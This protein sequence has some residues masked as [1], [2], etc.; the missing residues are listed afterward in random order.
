M[1]DKELETKV[2]EEI[3]ESDFA[4]EAKPVEKPAEEKPDEAPK[5]DLEGVNMYNEDVEVDPDYASG[6]NNPYRRKPKKGEEPKYEYETETQQKIE[7]ARQAF[8]AKYRKASVWKWI[9][10][11]LCLVGIV[12]G[13]VLPT[14][15]GSDEWKASRGPTFI[16]LG[17]LVAMILGL[18]IYSVFSKRANNKG[19]TL[20]LDEYYNLSNSYVFEGLN[21]TDVTGN[22]ADK[23]D[24]SDF[25]ACAL[26]N[27]VD[28]VGSRGLLHFEYKGI[29]CSLVDCSASTIIGRNSSTVFVGKMLRVEN[30][31]DADDVIVYIKGN[32]RA[33]PPTNLEGYQVVEDKKDHVVYGLTKKKLLPQKTREALAQIRTDKILVDCAIAIRKGTTYIMMGYEDSLMVPPLETPFNPGPLN[34]YKEDLKTV[35]AVAET[36]YR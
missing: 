10:T 7:A 13:Y 36:L 19:I 29:P 18:A 31:W 28:R 17:V 24:A 1:E 12:L 27:K 15:L 9:L 3:E 5:S 26:Y 20:Y 23:I 32:K 25:A 35:L 34:K 21:L 33:L 8:H 2:T 14:F 11:A 4:D 30:T 6:S 16:M 22:L